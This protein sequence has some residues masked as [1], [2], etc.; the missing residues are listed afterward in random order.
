MWI[1]VP[2]Y[3][4][5]RR[6]ILMIEHASA[7]QHPGR[8]MED[9]IGRTNW[10]FLERAKGLEPST[11]TLARSC[12]TTELHPH[13]KALAAIWHRQRRR[14]MPNAAG[15]CNSRVAGRIDTRGRTARLDFAAIR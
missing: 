6:A 12:S 7:R 3:K 10:K 1:D 8:M 15:E 4:T 14:A 2:V 5:E 9:K 11:P 13:P